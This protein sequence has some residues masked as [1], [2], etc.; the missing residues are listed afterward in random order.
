MKSTDEYINTIYNKNKEI[1]KSLIDRLIYN[2]IM[3]LAQKDELSLDDDIMKH[4]YDLDVLY[5]VRSEIQ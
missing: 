3:D 2:N 4:I 5:R 1:C